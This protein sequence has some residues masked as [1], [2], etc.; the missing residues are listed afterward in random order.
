MN[1]YLVL[2]L[3]TRTVYSVGAPGQ[4]SV[5][6]GGVVS[7]FERKPR[8]MIR[9]IK[10]LV[11]AIL[12]ATF[13]GTT[14]QAQ[15]T[16]NATSC[17]SSAVQAAVNS[18][19]TGDTVVIP[20][21]AQTNWGDNATSGLGS[22]RVTKCIEIKGSGQGV[23]I[24]GDNVLKDGTTNSMAFSINITCG[25][26]I[27]KLHDITLVGVAPDPS[28]H[29]KGH[30]HIAGS[31]AVPGGFRIYNVTLNTP[32]TQL[33][34]TDYVGPGLVDHV[35]VNNCSGGVG[36]VNMKSMNWGGGSNNFGDGSWSDPTP[37]AG[38]ANQVYI[39]DSTWNCSGAAPATAYD[40]DSGAH[41]VF[42]FNTLT[43]AN[44]GNHGTETSQRERSGRWQEYY[45]NSYTYTSNEAPDFV[46]FLRGGGAVF[47]GNTINAQ[48]GG[49]NHWVKAYNCRDGSS[50]ASGY[51]PWGFCNGSGAYDQNSTGSGYRCADQPGSGTSY[52]ASG[53]ISNGGSSI[54]PTIVNGVSCTGAA[55]QCWLGNI[56]DPAYSYLNSG[57]TP[58]F[59]EASSA[60]V[61][62]NRDV[63]SDSRGSSGVRNS[64]FANIPTTCIVNQ[65]YWA[66]DQGFWNTKT[67]GVAA[68]QL[69][70]CTASN[71]WTLYYTPYTY[72]HPLQGSSGPPPAP[73][74]GL[75]AIVN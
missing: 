36:G 20:A 12:L 64:T 71:T 66:T 11:L 58:S 18:A 46:V 23:T 9:I 19:A 72:P 28:I 57:T 73:P 74:T 35:T 4:Y 22:L 16:I 30:I 44:G 13:F 55:G 70:K 8:L 14:A 69:Y 67:P 37:V 53:G 42:R 31:S 38:S 5:V 65:A 26:G 52:T 68:G 25:T 43:D 40:G 27:F 49:I 41:W 1:W 54:G 75:S 24:I 17:S 10:W 48:G 32:Q 56:L 6:A 62:L 60:N 61:V 63:Y 47:W 29:S 33:I 21:C 7:R 15:T 2:K 50:C 39:E 34:A 59:T 3:S 45:K 51:P